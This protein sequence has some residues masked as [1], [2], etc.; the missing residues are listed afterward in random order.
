MAIL[1]DVTTAGTSIRETVPLLRAGADVRLAGLVVSVDRMERG[2]GAE[3]ALRE[4]AR[5][6]AMP[7]FAIVTIEEIIEHQ[8]AALD[9]ATLARVRAYREAYGSA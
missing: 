2:Q 5:E 9:E 7:T 4:L 1:E 6:F 8:R 3:S